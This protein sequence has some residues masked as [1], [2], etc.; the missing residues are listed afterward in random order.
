MNVEHLKTY[1]MLYAIAAVISLVALNWL[2]SVIIHVRRAMEEID[3]SRLDNGIVDWSNEDLH[4]HF[5]DEISLHHY[6]R[7]GK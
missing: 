5:R 3:R 7:S 2:V 1:G 4:P 6:S